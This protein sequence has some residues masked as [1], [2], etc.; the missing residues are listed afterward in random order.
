MSSTKV[1]ACSILNEMNPEQDNI[2]SLIRQAIGKEPFL[3][4]SRVADRPIQLM[5]LL[6]AFEQQGSDKLYKNSK[7]DNYHEFNEQSDNIFNGMNSFTS[8]FNGIKDPVHFKGHVSNA[9]GPKCT[10]AEMPSRK[11]PEAVVAFAQAAARATGEPEKSDIPGWPLLSPAKVQLQKCDKCSREFCSSVNYRRHRRIHRRS[12]NVDKLST[13]Q[14]KKLVSLKNVKVEEV[15]GPS[16][17]KALSTWFRRPGMLS[18]LPQVYIKAGLTLLDIVQESP[19]MSMSS[20]ELFSVLDDASEKTF[21]CAGTALS[22]QKYIFDVEAVKKALEIKN[23]VACTSFLI[24]IELVK[25]WLV[26]KEA[27]ALRCQKLL[28]DE[29]EAANRSSF[30]CC[31]CLSA[32]L[33]LS[34]RFLVALCV[35]HEFLFQERSI[36]PRAEVLEK[37]R[38]KKLRQK[39]QKVKELSSGEKVDIKIPSLDFPS[40]VTVSPDTSSPRASSEDYTSEPSQIQEQQLFGSAE[41]STAED[42]VNSVKCRSQHIQKQNSG[43]CGKGTDLPFRTDDPAQEK[44][45]QIHRASTYMQPS[46]PRH[47]NSKP[48]QNN[49]PHGFQAANNSTSKSSV[50]ANGRK[51]WTIKSKS[52]NEDRGRNGRDVESREVLIGSINVSLE[53]SDLHNS[54]PVLE[55]Q[56]EDKPVKPDSC[57]SS[58]HK[59]T[60]KLWRPVSRHG[61]EISVHNDCDDVKVDVPATSAAELDPHL[62][63]CEGATIFSGEAVKAFL[64]QRWK[65]AIACDDAVFISPPE[66]E[67]SGNCDSA[68]GNFRNSSPRTSDFQGRNVLGRVENRL[69]G[70][71]ALGTAASTVSWQFK[72]RPKTEKSSRLKYVPKQSSVGAEE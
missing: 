4:F 3:S 49:T 7:G 34:A 69:A 29:E 56:I 50:K 26:D 57:S 53:S 55:P 11:V 42:D 37:K 23:L 36:S 18:S 10:P 35:F 45:S 8:E 15:T 52:D 54:Y 40:D 13:D 59:T 33:E 38:L 12:L 5:Q 66:A 9:K 16:V 22:L 25:A 41:S 21:L 68:A 2:D 63:T 46:Y 43:H 27:E 48:N 65:E 60:T 17:I 62:D 31:L 1:R 44:L 71:C 61:N 28:V 72:S 20:E 51:V 39:E 58:L 14:A 24:E 67:A 19:S 47:P 32:R 30:L 6:S 64:A 70:A